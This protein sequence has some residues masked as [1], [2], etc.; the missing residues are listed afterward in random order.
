MQP[1]LAFAL[2][3]KQSYQ[4]S[5]AGHRRSDNRPPIP[6]LTWATINRPFIRPDVPFTLYDHLYLVAIYNDTS[7]IIVVKKSGQAGLSELFVS[8]ALHACDERRLDVLYIMPTDGDVSDFSRMRFGPA[9]EASPYL[10]S[11]VVPPSL[12][13]MHSNYRYRGADKISLKRIRDNWLVF[14]GGTVAQDGSARQLK[15]VPSDVLFFDE[16][17]EMNPQAIFIAQKRLGHSPIKEERYISTPS[18]PNIGIDS[19][20]KKSD[21]KEWFVP[22]PHCGRRQR[23]LYSNLVI[24][25]D[26]FDRPVAWNEVDGRPFIAC[27]K[28]HQ[29][30]NRLANGEWIAAN[31]G[32]AISGYH[33]TK[34]FSPHN[35]LKE[36]ID[37]QDTLDESKKREAVNQDLGEAYS[38]RG[39]RMAGDI[40]DACR[41]KYS[42]GVAKGGKRTFAGI[43]V[44]PRLK[45]LT[46][47][48][49]RDSKGNF[50]LLLAEE[51]PTFEELVY[52][53]KK[54][55]VGTCVI[56][57]LPET[58]KARELQAQM[59]KGRVWLAYYSLSNIGTKYKDPIQWVKAEGIVNADRTRVIDGMYARFYK[60]ENL[61]PENARNIPDYYD[62]LAA[63]VRVTEK[64]SRGIPVSRYVETGPDHYAHSETYCYVATHKAAWLVS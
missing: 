11:L 16:V 7:Q 19:L 23:L 58:T 35:T 27:T 56:D 9:I 37:N 60:Q 17:D 39:G 10:S 63:P 57:A 15:S 29:P 1:N 3:K 21:Q 28:C 30:M 41:R 64:D 5:V 12:G 13:K 8:M 33:P 50:R 22:C 62:Q 46:I 14:R 4:L 40:L 42:F 44:G 20:W 32:S 24:E 59:P 25:Q 43:D 38:P 2:A 45:H 36:I 18:Y 47:R 26:D 34:L 31:F 49:A 55:N 6:L 53:L 54:F 48:Q 61:L 52:I 51:V